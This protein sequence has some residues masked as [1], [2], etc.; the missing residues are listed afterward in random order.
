MLRV[1][2]RPSTHQLIPLAILLAVLGTGCG[3]ANAPAGRGAG[4][5]DFTSGRE[6]VC[7]GEFD[8][9]IGK[10]E[11]YL[12]DEPRGKFA[13]R[14]QFFV[15]KAHMGKLDLDAATTAFQ[16]TIDD[17]AGSLEAHKARYKLAQILLLQGDEKGALAAFEKIVAKQDSPLVPEATAYADHLEKKLAGNPPAGKPEGNG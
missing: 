16:K 3:G 6:L 9:G 17:H 4:G 10:L 7:R 15:A 1:S 12:K 2:V 11:E 5:G 13:S 8:K 14:A